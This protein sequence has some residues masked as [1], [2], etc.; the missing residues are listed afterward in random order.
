MTKKLDSGLKS[1][2][3]VSS[4]Q[5]F[6]HLIFLGRDN[7]RLVADVGGDPDRP[8]VILLHGGG[9]TRHSWHGTMRKLV[10]QGYYVINLDTRGH[11]DSEWSASG[12]YSFDAMADDLLAVIGSLPTLPA[13]VGASMGGC[14]ALWAVGRT[15]KPVASALVLVDVVPRIDPKG[16]GRIIA[17]M[18]SQPQGFATVEEAADAVA[19]YNPHR[20][21]PRDFRGLMR[22]LRY[23]DDGRLYWHWDPRLLTGQSIVEP[24]LVAK[25]MLELCKGVHVPSLL[26]RGMESEIVSE[27]GVAELRMHLP[28]VEVFDVANAGHMVAGDRNDIF[29]DGI[30]GFLAQ[31]CPPA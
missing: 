1:E 14:T 15:L 20:P 5:A 2:A 10:A 29:N 24:P 30:L 27:A 22:N 7:L 3:P 9:Q 13:L 21:R 17:F 8:S 28:Q 19:A 6:N 11:G 31:H 23:R 18:Q 12:D 26:V 25:R 4:S 16:A